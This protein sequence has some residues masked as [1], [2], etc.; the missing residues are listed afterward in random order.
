MKYS[1]QLKEYIPFNF[2][3]YST[4]NVVFIIK[5]FSFLK[6]HEDIG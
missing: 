5:L 2:L 1:I 3:K 4:I 6:I